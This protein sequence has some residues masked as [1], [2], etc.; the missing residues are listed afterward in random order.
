MIQWVIRWMLKML[1][2]SIGRTPGAEARMRAELHDV[3]GQVLLIRAQR[4]GLSRE[5]LL[6]SS[7][8]EYLI[9][10][11]QQLEK[12]SQALR[13]IIRESFGKTN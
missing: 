4:E 3:D 1:L 7:R 9:G 11:E 6:D 8:Y 10:L 13:Y 2:K 12:K 5:G